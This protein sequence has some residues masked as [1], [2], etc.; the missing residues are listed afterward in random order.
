MIT[1]LGQR[2]MFQTANVE[3][4]RTALEVAGQAQREAAHKQVLADRMA[5]AQDS[6][7]EIPHAEGM[8]TEERRQGRKDQE[9]PRRHG[10]AGAGPQ[11]DRGALEGAAISADGHMDF[12]A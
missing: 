10:A 6:V 3:A 1:P 11:E 7:P 8:K 9:P 5:E 12:L 2:Q 4:V